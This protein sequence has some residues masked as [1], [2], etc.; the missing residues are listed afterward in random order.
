MLY[1]VITM[2]RRKMTIPLFVGGAT[3]S[4]AH[5][6]LKIAPH[7]SGP[8]LHC[9][10]ASEAVRVMSEVMRQSTREQYLAN[11][12]KEYDDIRARFATSS[13]QQVPFAQAQANKRPFDVAT[14]RI[15]KPAKMGRF[16]IR[17][18]DLAQIREYIDWTFFFTS[19]DI[20]GI[21]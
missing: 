8:V 5:T 6:A 17:N 2:E 11:V 9:K 12:R 21:V 19:W 10:D 7:Y 1:E 20:K 15:V 14:A 16:E 4:K 3:T 13:K 18:Y